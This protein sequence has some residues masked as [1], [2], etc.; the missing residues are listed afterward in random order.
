M[1]KKLKLG[2]LKGTCE[3]H[4]Q[5]RNRMQIDVNGIFTHSAVFWSVLWAVMTVTEVHCTFTP[6][7][8]LTL[9][10]CTCLYSSMY[11]CV[12]MAHQLGQDTHMD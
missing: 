3:L 7:E 11:S 8:T 6:A 2:M 5:E 10:M 4:K 12:V 1:Q 9:Q